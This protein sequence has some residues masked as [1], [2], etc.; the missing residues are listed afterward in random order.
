MEP[1]HFVNETT[2][3]RFGQ[4]AFRFEANGTKVVWPKPP[5]SRAAPPRRIFLWKIIIN[6]NNWKRPPETKAGLI[7]GQ[8][9]NTEFETKQRKSILLAD[10]TFSP[11]SSPSQRVKWS[12][13]AKQFNIKLMLLNESVFRELNT[14]MLLLSCNQTFWP[15]TLPRYD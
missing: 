15:I 2:R 13:N 4:V 1:Q 6:R 12:V 8:T 3:R 14:K 7:R 11:A 9:P 5:I 10:Q